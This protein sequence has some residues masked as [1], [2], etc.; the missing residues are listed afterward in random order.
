M[1]NCSDLEFGFIDAQAYLRTPDHPLSEFFRKSFYRSN[2]LERAVDPDVYFLLGEKGTG[3]T[4]YAVY[5]S[6]F[7]KDEYT[8]SCDFFDTNDF[9]RFLEVCKSL[10]IEKSQFSVV[11]SLIFSLLLLQHLED[12]GAV[13]SVSILSKVL[14]ASQVVNLG[15]KLDTISKCIEVVSE[16][17]A[18]FEIYADNTENKIPKTTIKGAKPSFKIS[19]IVDLIS[20]GFGSI[21]SSLQQTIFVDGLDVRPEEVAYLDYLEV[22]SSICN[23]IWVVNSTQLAKLPSTMKIVL[24]LRPDIIESISFQNRGPKIQHH[25]H[26]VEWSTPYKDFKNSEIFYF[27]DLV[28][29]SQQPDTKQLESGDTW[30]SYF[31][32]TVKSRVNEDGDNPFILFLRYSFYKPRDIIKYLILMRNFYKTPERSSR[33]SFQNDVFNERM[34]TKEYS[35]YLMQEIRDQLSFYYTNSEYQ[36]FLDFNN[37]YLGQYIDKSKLNF[38]YDDF[39]KA[40]AEYIDYNRRNLIET[41]PSFAT[42]DQTLQFMFDLNVLG[43]WEEKTLRD[44]RTLTFTNYSFKQRGFA[45]LRPKVPSNSNY[46]MHFGV[47]KSLFVEMGR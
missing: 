37:G 41:V 43:Y 24:L 26:F 36:Q 16:I 30:N 15:G 39:L 46:V 11:W 20:D 42:A 1:K 21:G 40:H 31:P 17:D 13:A 29:F 19:R 2:H 33:T 28:L 23:A 34:I 25:G 12:R 38:S 6:L 35:S 4:A 32:F 8:A 44:G 45:N 18:V 47:A 9:T 7:M 27:T 22:V 14:S 3:K 10:S 5:A